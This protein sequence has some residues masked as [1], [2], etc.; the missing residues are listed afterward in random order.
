MTELTA[1]ELEVLREF[2]DGASVKEVAGRLGITYYT[3]R[4]Y[5]TRIY[6]KLGVNSLI[7][8]YRV[9]GWIVVDGEDP[10]REAAIDVARVAR[11]LLEKSR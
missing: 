3:L 7:G 5:L 1:R 9:K 8:S 2:K 4:S 10:L 11:L 6:R